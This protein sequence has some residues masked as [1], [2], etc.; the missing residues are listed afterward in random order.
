MLVHWGKRL[1]LSGSFLVI[2]QSNKTQHPCSHGPDEPTFSERFLR[3]DFYI[4]R[5]MPLASLK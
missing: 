2:K 1:G 3:M 5:Q 4:Q